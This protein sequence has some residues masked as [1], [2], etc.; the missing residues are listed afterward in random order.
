MC[1]SQSRGTDSTGMRRSCFS[2]QVGLS[3]LIKL[4]DGS[5]NMGL[6]AVGICMGTLE[7]GTHIESVIESAVENPYISIILLY[8]LLIQIECNC[9]ILALWRRFLLHGWRDFLLLWM[10]AYISRTVC[11]S[12]LRH[13][14]HHSRSK[15]D[16][17]DKYKCP[18]QNVY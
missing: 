2:N 15:D 14:Y 4:S 10:K 6:S 18:K 7:K 1:W 11:V 13:L 17:F 5:V 3:Q 16:I 9:R 12:K 8:F